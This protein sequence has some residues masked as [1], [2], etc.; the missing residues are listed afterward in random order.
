MNSNFGVST[1]KKKMNL[2]F[3]QVDFGQ[4][5]SNLEHFQEHQRQGC[6]SCCSMDRCFF[7]YVRPLRGVVSRISYR[8]GASSAPESSVIKQEG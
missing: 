6:P 3:V 4:I 1:T 5:L 2:P 7:L 8:R